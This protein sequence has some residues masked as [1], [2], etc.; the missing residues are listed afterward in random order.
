MFIKLVDLICKNVSYG[1]FVCYDLFV[2]YSRD[3]YL[4]PPI[5]KFELIEITIYCG[6]IIVPWAFHPPIFQ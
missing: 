6:D 3:R 2:S 1:F 5:Y 4:I